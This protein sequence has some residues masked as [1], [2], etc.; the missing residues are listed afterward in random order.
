MLPGKYTVS[1][2]C[3]YVIL[4]GY[5]TGSIIMIFGNWQR[6]LWLKLITF[7]IVQQLHC[8]VM[9]FTESHLPLTIYPS[10]HKELLAGCLI[11]KICQQ[12]PLPTLLNDCRQRQLHKC[13]IKT[14]WLVN[15]EKSSHYTLTCGCYPWYANVDKITKQ[16]NLSTYQVDKEVRRWYPINLQLNRN[17]GGNALESRCWG[18]LPYCHCES[19]I[20]Y[21]AV[22]TWQCIRQF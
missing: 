9:C 21:K 12:M 15:P 10:L 5:I 7:C 13:V 22:P 19:H 6:P 11:S 2:T 16:A 8:P 20:P 17:W 1:H 14:N 4:V 18:S 3:W